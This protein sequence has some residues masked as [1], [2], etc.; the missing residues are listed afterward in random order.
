MQIFYYQYIFWS[1]LFFIAH[2]LFTYVVLDFRTV[3]VL[4]KDLVPRSLFII[5]F[6]WV[7]WFCRL[8]LQAIILLEFHSWSKITR[9]IKLAIL[10][11]S[12]DVWP[13][14]DLE[15][16]LRP[17][18][19]FCALIWTKFWTNF[20]YWRCIYQSLYISVRTLLE[21]DLFKWK[22]P[23]PSTVGP[24]K[25]DSK[26]CVSHEIKSGVMVYLITYGGVHIQRRQHFWVF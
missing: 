4:R 2:T 11:C 8:W 23:T 12:D 18:T 19:T 15:Y 1:V 10:R 6:S 13:N 7:M 24:L 17:F 21:V 22:A 14:I 9:S 26:N 5:F 3:V 25:N 16:F 20:N